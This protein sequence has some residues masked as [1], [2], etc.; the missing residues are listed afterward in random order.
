M[1]TCKSCSDDC[2]HDFCECCDKCVICGLFASPPAAPVSPGSWPYRTP[3]S[4]PPMWTPEYY[5]QF[6]VTYT[7]PQPQMVH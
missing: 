4:R 6:E 7:A 2:S 5:E 3:G 1:A